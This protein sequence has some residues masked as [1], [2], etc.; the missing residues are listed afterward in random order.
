VGRPL[1]HLHRYFDATPAL[2]TFPPA[3]PMLCL[4]RVWTHPG[5]ILKKLEVH[6]TPLARVASD[7]LPSSRR[8]SCS[9]SPGW[10]ARRRGI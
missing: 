5:T 1:R 9:A 10:R 6:K 4:D 7:H 2:R 8:S 3:R